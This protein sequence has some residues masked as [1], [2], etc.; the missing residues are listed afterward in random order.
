MNQTPRSTQWSAKPASGLRQPP[1]AAGPGAKKKT[2]AKAEQAKLFGFFSLLAPIIGGILA[3]TGQL[4]AGI[5]AAAVGLAL[6]LLSLRVFRSPVS[7][8]PRTLPMFGSLLCLHIAV[9]IAVSATGQR[10]P[11]GDAPLDAAAAQAGGAGE[12]ALAPNGDNRDAGSASSS[13]TPPVANAVVEKQH[14]AP[15]VKKHVAGH[16]APPG[17]ESLPAAAPNAP[18]DKASVPAAAPNAPADTAPVPS[19]T[20]SV[21]AVGKKTPVAGSP[22]DF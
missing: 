16:A 7:P 5:L 6:G 11:A 20:P 8:G 18:T 3:L 12:G 14:A 13:K 22:Q 15:A 4:V 1:R 21:P 19:A 2:G 17:K 10:P 9:L